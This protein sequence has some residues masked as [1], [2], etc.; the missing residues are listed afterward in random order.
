MFEQSPIYNVYAE[1]HLLAGAA[2][3]RGSRPR[4]QHHMTNISTV[5]NRSSGGSILDRSQSC[6]C[7]SRVSIEVLGWQAH[8]VAVICTHRRRVRVGGPVYQREDRSFSPQKP[9]GRIQIVTTGRYDLCARWRGGSAL[10]FP[11][12]IASR[13]SVLL[14][15]CSLWKLSIL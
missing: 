10:A 7:P 11:R 9:P 2:L 13:I 8:H 14:R 15:R 12:G 6:V 5:P 4:A 3:L 1:I